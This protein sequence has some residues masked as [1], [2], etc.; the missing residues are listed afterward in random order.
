M[1]MPEKSP[2]PLEKRFAG[3]SQR[4]I[5]LEI[6]STLRDIR[7]L[8]TEEEA[9]APNPGTY[10]PGGMYP[11]DRGIVAPI[12]GMHGVDLDEGDQVLHTWDPPQ[13]TYASGRYVGGVHKIAY[14]DPFQ[15]TE[16]TYPDG[17]LQPRVFTRDEVTQY[18][19]DVL[20]RLLEDKAPRG[21]TRKVGKHA[22]DL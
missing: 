10:A 2:T 5:Q 4:A 18:G 15:G 6:L 12:E 14:T 3:W 19:K 21:V 13:N 20:N 17:M 8:L 11:P 22:R 1:T 7:E 16:S 9:P